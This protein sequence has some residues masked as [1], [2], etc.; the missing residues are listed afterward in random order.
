MKKFRTAILCVLSLA[1]CISAFA[2]CGDRRAD[3][4]HD[5]IDGNVDD[6]GNIVVTDDVTI[7]FWGWGS[8]TEEAIYQEAIADFE[9]LHD[10][11]TVQYSCYSSDT[12]MTTLQSSASNLPDLFYMPDEEFMYWA[13]N[14]VL[15]DFSDYVTAEERAAIWEEGLARYSYNEDTGYVG[16]SEGAGLYG[17]PKDLGPFTFAYNEDLLSDAL[18][19]AREQGTMQLTLDEVKEEY[20]DASDPM[21]WEEFVTLGSILKPYCDKNSQYVLS[22]YEVDS[23]IYSNNASYYD[24]TVTTQTMTD[25]Q[26][27]DAWQW[28]HDLAF[29]YGLMPHGSST[30]NGYQMFMAGNAVFSFV[31]PWDCAAIWGTTDASTAVRYTMRLLPVPYGPGADREY[32][33]ADDGVSTTWIGSMGYCISANSSTTQKAAA[34][35][36]A[37]YLCSN[38][39]AQT[40]F[41]RLGQQVPNLIEMA[42][43]DYLAMKTVTNSRGEEVA[44]NPSNLEVFL[45][46]MD[47][48]DPA[49]G[50]FV[51]GRERPTCNILHT[52][53]DKDLSYTLDELGFWNNADVTGQNLVDSFKDNMQYYLDYHNSYLG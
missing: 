42:E 36:L 14:G 10:N 27:V 30:T 45:D 29:K 47:G 15:W 37:K 21:T 2:G 46:V 38:E 52:D 41:Y 19:Y 34:L 33:T 28:M 17:L 51:G 3:G 1:V 9:A 8:T 26:F 43:T 20:L 35:L 7:R 24:E 53:W 5:S 12:Y 11:I 40:K 48:T 25:P 50:D 13:Y 39:N 16:I 4:A 44:V 32:G 23:A 49:N 31:G 18:D 22:H 6:D